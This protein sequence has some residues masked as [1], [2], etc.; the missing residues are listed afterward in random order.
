MNRYLWRIICS[1]LAYLLT[2]S[3]F[4]M[5]VGYI[6]GAYLD[7]H[8]LMGRR[9]KFY[10]RTQKIFFNASFQVLGYIAKSDG[11][12]SPN[13]IHAA[14]NI[15]R[16]MGLN[17]ELRQKAIYLFN[18]G[19]QPNFN[20]SA[21]LQELKQACQSHPHL[22][23]MFIEIQMQMA[24]ADSRFMSPAKQATL[25]HICQMLGMPPIGSAKFNQQRYQ[26]Q[27]QSA[28][29][30]PPLQDDYKALNIS[31][32]AT[33]TEVK[34]A[35]RKAMSKNHPDRMIAEGVPP[36]MLKLATKKTQDIKAAYERIKKAR[37]I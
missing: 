6:I 35:Y 33:D 36:E 1:I 19:K 34:K 8:H 22:L 25:N 27:H 9:K 31:R 37:G 7:Q 4:G 10:N 18:Q 29:P 14:E 11:H 12:V 15:M 28:S 13:E 30:K 21:V 23:Q 16:Q 2:H 32:T 26:R 3:F 17:A 5:I 20:P 24:C